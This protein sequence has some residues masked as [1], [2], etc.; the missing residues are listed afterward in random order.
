[1]LVMDS[2][3]SALHSTI[4]F[5][6]LWGKWVGSW[7][8]SKAIESLLCRMVSPNTGL[9]CTALDARVDPYWHI[10]REPKPRPYI[11]R[12]L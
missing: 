9:R 11:V 12:P 5:W 8:M 1:M 10:K 7:K 2:K 4:W 6:Q 3:I